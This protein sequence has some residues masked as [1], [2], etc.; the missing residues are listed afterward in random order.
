MCNGYGICWEG[1]VL[2]IQGGRVSM[3]FGWLATL[4]PIPMLSFGTVGLGTFI[5]GFASFM[6]R[7]MLNTELGS[8]GLRV[9][10]TVQAGFDSEALPCDA[11]LGTC[12][13]E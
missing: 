3:D 1:Q 6:P 11:I 12:G 2:E 10:V 5:C 8:T 13:R 9:D 4:I 7:G